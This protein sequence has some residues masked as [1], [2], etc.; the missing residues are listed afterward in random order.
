M[1][2]ILVIEDMDSLREEILEALVCEGFQ[3]FGAENG[4]VGVQIAQSQ[5]PDLIICDVMMPEL[6]G[7]GTLKQ[8][9][10]NQATAT[11]PFVFL[12]ARA[13]KK[14]MRHGMEL[15]ADDYLVKPFTTAE[16]LGAIHSR[17]KK[18]SIM[19]GKVKT[20]L[21]T[22]RSSI[23]RSLPHELRTPLN[24][25]M[26]FSE[27][28]IEALDPF[29]QANLLEIAEGIHNSAHHLYKV[30]QR[31]LLY[32]ELEISA[33]SSQPIGGTPRHPVSFLLATTMEVARDKAKEIDRLADIHF[34][35]PKT[36]DDQAVA[37]I[38][39]VHIDTVKFY[40]IVEELIDNC[41][42]YSPVG[43]LVEI[44]TT[45]DDQNFALHFVDYGRGMTP[46]QIRNIGAYIQFERKIYEQQGTGLG[47]VIVKRIIE[48]ANG[49]LTIASTPWEYTKVSIFLPLI[50]A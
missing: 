3:V 42:K 20:E 31:F 2:A 33:K 24:G 50:H 32:A 7:Y 45:M 44:T 8:L 1:S 27:L 30:I 46:E 22:L 19:Q 13:E 5:L 6:D 41:L 28:L 34:G 15:G 35:F 21:D 48:A 14:D 47:L 17:L 16:L 4:A 25:I 37:E 26:G 9:R 18:Q 38:K 49:K 23:A 39:Y 40:K 10:Q 36:P 29:E 11:I 12:T 43:K